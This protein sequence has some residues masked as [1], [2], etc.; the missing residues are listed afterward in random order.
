MAGGVSEGGH[1][2]PEGDREERE[3]GTLAS[4]SVPRDRMLKKPLL[5]PCPLQRPHLGLPYWN[6][7]WVPG[8]GASLPRVVEVDGV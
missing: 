1:Q 2:K 7:S 3:L 4:Y 8:R 5:R 6:K